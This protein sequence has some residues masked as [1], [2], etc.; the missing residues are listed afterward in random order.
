MKPHPKIKPYKTGHLN[1]GKGHKIYY[2]LVGNPRGKPILFVHGGPGGGCS[3]D[4]RR[5]FNPKKFN[6]ILFDQRG[7]GR[8]KPFASTHANTT[9]ELVEDMQKLLSHLGIKKAFLFGGSWGSTLS[10]AYAA[11][12]PQSVTGMMLRGIFLATPEET[13][14]AFGGG[15]QKHFPEAWERFTS[16]V[17]KSKRNKIVDYY[18]SKMTSKNKAVRRKHSYEWSYYEM[19]M[20]K[21]K[22]SPEDIK[23]SLSKHN[24]ESLS[25]LEAHYAKNDFFI[26]KGHLLKSAKKMKMPVVIIQGRYDAITPPIAAWKLHKTLPR[27]KLIFTVAGHGSSDQGNTQA[28]LKEL[29]KIK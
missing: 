13:K 2:E 23:K 4:D 15:A 12:H 3:A 28:I 24:F 25:V 26:K 18:L 10:L 16:I 22:S 21:L 9:P 7:A 8:S 27:S 1:V 17:P 11:Q 19:S 5:F 20:L 29:K 6:V 14:H